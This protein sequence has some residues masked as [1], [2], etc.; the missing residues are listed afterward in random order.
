VERLRVTITGGTGLIGGRLAHAL[1]RDGDEVTVV[2]REWPVDVL[3]GR[4]AVVHLA[5]ENIAQ[6]WS[7]AAKA[8]IRA[9]RVEG[10]HRLVMALG[11]AD[12]RPRILVS[13]SGADYYGDQGDRRVDES[14]S[15][16]EAFL[17]QVCVEWEHE[18]EAAT[19]LGLRVT[20][21]RT[22]PVLDRRG[23]ALAKM[24]PPFRLGVGGPVAGGRQWLPWISLDD[25]A[26]VYADAVHGGDEWAG[27]V[28]AC[29][30]EPVTNAAF[31]K[32]LGRALH[33][34]AALPVPAFALH[35]LYGEMATIVTGGVRM[36]PT[37][38]TQELGY[39]YRHPD[40]DAALASALG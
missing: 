37:R 31:S 1:R 16:G 12:P 21:L 2:G 19:D 23:G 24:L 39:R 20:R 34:P 28:N 22:G 32:A 13:A 15:P 40:L 36:I 25:I 10:T 30:P 8:R 38:L 33:R 9:S 11:K 6:R 17:A 35:A 3:A 7:E 27:A 29:A 18:A 26:G 5:G 14:S 4:D